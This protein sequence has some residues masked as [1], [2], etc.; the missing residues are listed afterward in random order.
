MRERHTTE[1]CQSYDIP[2]VSLWDC[3][4]PEC[5]KLQHEASDPEL[6]ECWDCEAAQEGEQ[7]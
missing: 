1:E 3:D 6:C 7:R 2:G 4:C 5:S